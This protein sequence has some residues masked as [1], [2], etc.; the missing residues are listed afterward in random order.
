MRVMGREKGHYDVHDVPYGKDYS[1][2]PERV[3]FE[4]DC[5][6]T[7]TWTAPVTACRCGTSYTD[8]SSRVPG[9]RLTNEEAYR[10]C[11]EEYEEW[12]REK[13]ANDLRHE[14]LGFVKAD[15]ND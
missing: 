4:C 13:L 10:P 12:R 3:L 9:G 6:E 8:V 7:L 11:L 2:R 15:G 5:G 1:W 14:Y